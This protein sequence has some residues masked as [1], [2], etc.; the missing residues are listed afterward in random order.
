MYSLGRCQST[1]GTCSYGMQLA[2]GLNRDCYGIC[3]Q[4][5]SSHP[6]Y[7]FAALLVLLGEG[8]AGTGTRGEGDGVARMTNPKSG[9]AAEVMAVLGIR[10]SQEDEELQ[11]HNKMRQ[12]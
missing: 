3:Q 1:W 5:I 6:I 12:T 9:K 10:R 11:Q 8:R 2:Q 4:E 7:A